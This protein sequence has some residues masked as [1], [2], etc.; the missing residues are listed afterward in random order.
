MPTFSCHFHN[1]NLQWQAQNFP[2]L[3]VIGHA[4]ISG[5]IS[6]FVTEKAVDIHESICLVILC[7]KHGCLQAEILQGENLSTA[8]KKYVCLSGHFSLQRRLEIA[9]SF[10][11]QVY[12]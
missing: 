3:V 4:L 10:V 11:C 9:D 6:A 7:C 5:I 2:V 12:G 1:L 8:Y